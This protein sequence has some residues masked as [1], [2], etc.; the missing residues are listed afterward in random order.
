MPPQQPVSVSSRRSLDVISM[1][2]FII[3]LVA[4]VFAFIPSSSVPIATLK[5]FLLSGGAIV[6][7]ALYILARLGRGNMIFPP[8]AL[9]GAL[10][11]PTIAYALSTA[12]SGVSFENS[13]WGT[14]FEADTLGFMGAAACLGTLAALVVRRPE[15]YHSFLRAGAYALGAVVALQALVLVVG[16]FFPGTVSPA[17][18]PTGSFSDLASL[19]GLGVV[20]ILITLRF[21]DLAPRTGR[22]LALIGAV[23][24]F[25]LAVANSS[26]VWTLVAL[27]SLGLF[28][29]AVMRRGAK[30]VDADLDEAVVVDEAP[31]EAEEGNRS[32]VMPLVVLAVSLFF[33]IG[34]ALGGALA[35]SLHVN[36][37]NV[38]PSWQ[39]TLSVAQ[40][41][42]SAFGSGPSTFGA[43]WVKY[44]DASLNSTVFWN[45]DFSSGI[46]FIPTSFVTT[47]IVGALAWLV[48]LALLIGLG[49]RTLILRTPE[50]AFIQYVSIVSFV[51]AVYL[52]AI[53]V[54]DLPSALV[55]VLAFVFAGIFA[56][57]TRHAAGGRQWGVIFSR[58]PRLGFV[59]VFSLTILL[60]ASVVAAYSLV[61]HYVSRSQLASAVAALSAGDLDK[62]D[63]AAR[64]SI[65]FAPS[66]AAYQ[67][68][69][70]I[71]NER[72][73]RIAASSTLSRNEAQQAYQTALSAGVNAAL[74]ATNLDPSHYQNW[75][76]LGNLYAQAVPLRVS[77]AYESAK[78][79][80]EKARAQSP[81]NP[82][83]PYILAQLEIANRNV[84]AAKENLKA[85][86][87]LKQD[88]A[89]A[90]F[91]LSQ[92]EVQE[93]NIKD[94]L[95][96]ALA[97]A[98]FT[99]NDPNVLFQ[100]GI[101]Y[102]AQNDFANAAAALGA[103][104]TANPQFANARYFLSAVYAKQGDLG[105]A[106]AQMQAIA[107]MSDENAKAVA[108]QL[109]ALQAGK[110]PFPANLLTVS[111]T[112]VK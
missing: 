36:V 26:L 22:A 69:A 81:T 72:L 8:L 84:A 27:S 64:S 51:G 59:I 9:V 95:A 25:L 56:S 87:A 78:T 11:L 12:F 37:L 57:T 93:G 1:W 43:E 112:P 85:A 3:T 91:L 103:A 65:S 35:S 53:A 80:Y 17:F 23:A 63:E 79:A 111:S 83:I 105:S 50:D 6:T 86:I 38:R 58:S 54:F 108:A 2:A 88:Y 32:L 20:A 109:S 47:G 82:Q 24:L 76:A 29:E 55:L 106:L 71:A 52:F 49:L 4:A 90:I 15:H 48:L 70:S 19:L 68:Q 75:L 5:A 28:V 7:L 98:Y 107:A 33:L 41:T 40:K 34:G 110:N 73:N 101:L 14:A 16:Q 96:S 60:L 30:T 13:F 97:A 21:L 62:A 46:G 42:Y 102:A 99:P 100:V 10:W 45:A 18:S 92:L 61:E 89:T 104:V 66:A 94:A 67:V 77:G 31:L 44:R 74:T 39:S